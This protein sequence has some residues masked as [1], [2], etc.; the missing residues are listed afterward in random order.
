MAAAASYV[1]R[2]CGRSSSAGLL[3]DAAVL[4]GHVLAAAGSIPN[5]AVGRCGRK[6]YGKGMY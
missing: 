2:V 5:A 1:V 3:T 4:L 6:G